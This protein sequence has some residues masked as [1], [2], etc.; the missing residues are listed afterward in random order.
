MSWLVVIFDRR[1]FSTHD[2]QNLADRTQ[3]RLKTGL[4]KIYVFRRH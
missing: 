2:A 4:L 1:S 3:K